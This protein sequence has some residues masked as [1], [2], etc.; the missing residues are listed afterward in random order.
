MIQKRR[1]EH[2]IIQRPQKHKGKRRGDGRDKRDWQ[3]KLRES[4]EDRRK[5]RGR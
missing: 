5:E 2:V 4:E 1:N 3:D